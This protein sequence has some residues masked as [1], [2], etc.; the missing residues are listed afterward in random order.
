M[1][2][3]RASLQH[4]IYEARSFHYYADPEGKDIVESLALD[5]WETPAEVEERGGADCDGLSVW[6]LIRACER[7]SGGGEWALVA[8]R[9]KQHGQWLG[10][11]W[12]ELVD[13]ESRWWADPTWGWLPK[14]PETHGYPSSRVPSLRWVYDPETR[15]FPRQESYG[16]PA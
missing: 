12:V 9:V 5:R 11:A 7:S 10:H 14:Y 3:A 1:S 2:P 15:T 4:R 13:D 16:E 6:C 8:G